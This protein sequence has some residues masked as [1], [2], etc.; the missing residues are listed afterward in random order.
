MGISVHGVKQ[1]VKR[2]RIKRIIREFY[3][4]NKGFIDPP[5]DIVI[6]VRKN[7]APTSPLE[8]EQAFEPLVARYQV[9]LSNGPQNVTGSP[10]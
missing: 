9:T 5:S 1:A 7:F 4:L 10:S 8:V 2:N 6:A 3:R